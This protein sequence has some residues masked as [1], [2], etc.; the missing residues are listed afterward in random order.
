M[1]RNFFFA[2]VS[3]LF[4]VGM[5]AQAPKVAV[6]NF[7]AGSGVTQRDAESVMATFSAAFAPQGWNV[8]GAAQIDKAVREQGFRKSALPDQQVLRLG[9][10]L[11]LRDVIVGNY[12]IS[13]GKNRLT[14]RVL[15]VEKERVAF[16]D[17]VLWEK[18]TPNQVPLH[19]LAARVAKRIEAQ[20]QLPE[21]IEPEQKD[22]K[23]DKKDLTPVT[24]KTKPGKTKGREDNA[25][26]QSTDTAV[27]VLWGY[28]RIHPQ[29]IGI[30]TDE[31][32]EL[33]ANLNK[34]G[35]FDYDGWRIPTK[36]EWEVIM[37][38]LSKVSGIAKNK[39]YMTEVNREDGKPKIVRLVT[40]E[41]KTVTQKRHE[42]AEAMERAVAEQMRQD[43]LRRV[44]E[45]RIA[46]Q[47]AA[48]QKR[49]REE[50]EKEAQRL[51]KER[52]KQKLE[53]RKTSPVQAVKNELGWDIEIKRVP[54]GKVRDRAPY[55]YHLAN[56]SEM[57][58]MCY[59]LG[60]KWTSDDYFISSECYRKDERFYV[61]KHDKHRYYY[62][63]DHQC[64]CT[65]RQDKRLYKYADGL[66]LYRTSD[67]VGIDYRDYSKDKIKNEYAGK[68]MARDR[69][70]DTTYVFAVYVK[71]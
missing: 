9:K 49:L 62:S 42:E 63:L 26:P 52:E 38:S 29:N 1:P 7:K 10:Q 30:F 43:S 41:S 37:S 53:L 68:L 18:F 6:V 70:Y 15:D 66:F 25:V 48:E 28:L 39:A 16:R 64:W 46:A 34:N 22:K 23:K 50:R 24:P 69:A 5:Y 58:A 36:E 60:S 20:R 55:G 14:V 44:E 57:L 45:E 11:G 2:F 61:D 13:N 31:P 12:G 71:D 32:L 27:V 40:T 65:S 33:I 51:A 3:C 56:D 35:E 67:G 59:A 19:T 21:P 54:L 17:S 47:N 4:A 8:V